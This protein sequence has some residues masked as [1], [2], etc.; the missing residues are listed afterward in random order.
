MK[1]FFF[2]TMVT[3]KFYLNFFFFGNFLKFTSMK[4]IFNYMFIFYFQEFVLSMYVESI[5][6]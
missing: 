1:L 2:K 3:V 4:T 6:R 5:G